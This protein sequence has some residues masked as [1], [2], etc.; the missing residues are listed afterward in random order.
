MKKVKKESLIS[1]LTIEMG[2]SPEAN[3]VN[4]DGM[5]FPLLNGP[6]E[7]T[8]RYPIPVQYTTDA[9]RFANKEDILFCVRGSTTGRMNIADQKYAIGRG[10]AAISHIQGQYLNSFVKG[11]LDMNLKNLLGGTLGSVFPNLTK[12]QL[13]EFRCIVPSIGEQQKIATV[14][15]SIDDKIALNEKLNDNLERMAKAIYNYW[16]VQFD[17]PDE[18]GKPYKS[19]GG[20]MVYNEQLKQEI[21]EGWEVKNLDFISTITGGSTPSKANEANFTKGGKGVSWITPKDLSDNKINK[22]ISHGEFDVTD[23]GLKEASLKK[24]PQETVLMSSRAPIGYLAIASNEVT[25]NQGFKS[26]VPKA[27][28]TSEFI[29]YKISNLL[30]SII[31]KSSGSTFKEVSTTTLKNIAIDVPNAIVLKQYELIKPLFLNQKN[32]EMQN[33]QLSALRDWLLP[34]LM[35]GQVTV[36]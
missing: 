5:G 36:D 32:L 30:P 35:N 14:L 27:H 22:F 2:Q 33:Q 10:L 18:N 19:S 8:N 25:T 9:K 3:F 31:N 21:P 20:K 16:F 4:K 11:L 29:F 1:F 28:Y 6:A 7:F 26:F 12:D 15:S 13:F 17:F 34:M 24:M 23:I